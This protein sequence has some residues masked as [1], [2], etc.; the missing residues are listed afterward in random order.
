MIK[1]KTSRHAAPWC[2]LVLLLGAPALQAEQAGYYRWKDD[3]GQFQATQQPPT[4]RPSEYVKLST[5]KSQPMAPGENTGGNGEP[6]QGTPQAKAA[7]GQL[8]G[9]P[10]RNPEKCTEAKNTQAVLDSH[11]RIRSKDDNGEYRY[12]TPEEISE[13][14][15]LAQ[16]SADVYCEPAPK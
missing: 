4:D 3:K 10:E 1:T 14:K 5:G 9:L 6:A 13:Q 7:P 12:L 2:A 11:A 8:E 16:Q 15:R